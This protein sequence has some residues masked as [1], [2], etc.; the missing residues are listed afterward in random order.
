MIQIAT[1]PITAPITV[2]LLDENGQPTQHK[3]LIK[4]KRKKTLEV[5]E[6]IANE[7]A[8][9][10]AKGNNILGKAA[11]DLRWEDPT[12]SLPAEIAIAAASNSRVMTQLL[13][14]W[15]FVDGD[16]KPWPCTADNILLLLTGPEGPRFSSALY[17]SLYQAYGVDPQGQVVNL[18][19]E[20]AA[21]N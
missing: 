17:D 10:D 1:G 8:V 3:G 13:D 18:V 11:T 7:R 19:T 20:G 2:T 16:N 15:D 4:W 14:G 5:G 9:T 12:H 21:K 6:I